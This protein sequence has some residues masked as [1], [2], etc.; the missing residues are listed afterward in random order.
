MP[1]RGT[2]TPCCTAARTRAVA[3]GKLSR[4]LV[5]STLLLEI[6]IR[7]VF[8]DCLIERK[9]VVE[10]FYAQCL[11]LA[12]FVYILYLS[13]GC[14]CFSRISSVSWLG[15]LWSSSIN[16]LRL[17]NDSLK[18]TTKERILYVGDLKSPERTFHFEQKSI[19]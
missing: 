4:H 2:Q 14:K 17:F 1:W 9:L 7:A 10:A 13:Y 12:N 5:M 18:S 6:R 15:K 19:G 11:R 3:F 8:Q 16:Q